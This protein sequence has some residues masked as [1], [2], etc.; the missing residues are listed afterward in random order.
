MLLTENSF[1]LRNQ[2]DYNMKNIVKNLLNASNIT[3]T[4]KNIKRC[5]IFVVYEFYGLSIKYT[6]I[7]CLIL[8]VIAVILIIFERFRKK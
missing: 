8:G 5:D 4:Y 7:I 3:Y 2:N 6:L 1:N